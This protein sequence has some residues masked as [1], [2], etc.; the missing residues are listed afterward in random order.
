MEEKNTKQQDTVQDKRTQGPRQ[1]TGRQ[2][3]SRDEIEAAFRNDSR[4]PPLLSLEQA[5]QLAHLAPSTI[6]R[7]ASEGCFRNSVRRGKPIAFWRDR[8]VVEVMELDNSRKRHKR[9]KWQ[10]GEQ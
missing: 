9:A 2:R 1:S 4:F 10:K 6:K 7:L 5:A 3:L 8:F